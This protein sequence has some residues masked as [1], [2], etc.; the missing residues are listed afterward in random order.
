MTSKKSSTNKKSSSRSKNSSQNQTKRRSLSEQSAKSAHSAQSRSKESGRAKNEQQ[1]ASQKLGMLTPRL[2]NDII[3]VIVIAIS[4]IL[5]IAVCMNS[6]ALITASVSN[7]MHYGFGLGAYILPVMLFLFGICFFLLGRYELV[8]PRIATGMILIFLSIITLYGVNA[9]GAANRLQSLFAQDYLLNCGGYVGNGIAYVLLSLVG[10]AIS[11]VI[12]AA[13]IVGSLVLIGFSIS[14]FFDWLFAR[15]RQRKEVLE[16]NSYEAPYSRARGLDINCDQTAVAND[17]RAGGYNNGYENVGG[18][19][20]ASSTIELASAGGKSG[21]AAKT[22]M[23]WGASK[24]RDL[25][26][27][28]AGDGSG[29]GAAYDGGTAGAG[30]GAGATRM[31]DGSD[32]GAWDPDGADNPIFNTLD[33]EAGTNILSPEDIEYLDSMD[34]DQ[35]KAAMAAASAGVAGAATVASAANSAAQTGDDAAAANGYA[36][37]V[38][39]G[40]DSDLGSSA[41]ADA[42]ADTATA[43][44]QASPEVASKHSSTKQKRRNKKDTVKQSKADNNADL[45]ADGNKQENQ[46]GEFVL[47]DLKFLKKSTLKPRSAA[48]NADLAEL[49]VRLQETLHEF[50]VDADVVGWVHGP[51]VTLFKVSLASGVRV[52]KITALSDDIALA[53]ASQSVRIFSPIAGTSLVGIEIP[54]DARENVLLGDVLPPAGT[55]PMLMGIGK[56]VEGNAITADL[57][58]MPHLLIGGTTGSGKSVAINSMIMS[59]L[60]RAKPEEVRMILIDPK[61]VE[62][63][64]YNDIPHLFVP[65]V[66][67]PHKA[68]STLAWAVQEMERRLKLF[69]E[70][71]AR[72]ITQYSKLRA[73]ALEEQ[74]KRREEI[75]KRCKEIEEQRNDEGELSEELSAELTELQEEEF[76]EWEQMPSMMIVIDELADLMMV[77]GKEVETSISRIAQLARAAGI[78]MIVATQRP[79]TN[80]ITGLIKANITNRIAFNVASGIDSRV[81]LDTTGAEHLIG[82]GD[83][84]FSKPEF[85]KPLRIQGCF[86]GEDEINKVCKFLREQA[87]PDYH[88]DIFT[89]SVPILEDGGSSGGAG[90]G[91]SD[92]DLLW[93]AADIVVSSHMGSTSAIQRRL[94]VGYA[95]AGRIMDML[96][97]KGIVGPANGSKPREV[98]IDQMELESLKVMEQN[99]L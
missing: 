65:V 77:A 8:L 99:G 40:P 51:T 53:F 86:V 72:N 23:L 42:D 5:M 41:G 3:G 50:N 63:S 73:D 59:V 10:Q 33:S 94:K 87:K 1:Y 28:Q 48:S 81:I 6:D 62:L 18:Y 90:G 91:T 52:N 74:E 12:L 9:P 54:N 61:R 7:G 58:K 30:V 38:D 71:G 32:G 70:V 45:L 27:N 82:L 47:P 44:A 19:V 14:G 57:A 64:L 37:D 2:K 17:P 97:D 22:R 43:D 60:M 35:A 20:P 92:E 16:N 68:A 25:N 36:E 24:T 85:G 26:A 79:S 83:L 39:L 80:V 56:D 46:E 76:D 4:I 31:L 89:T 75:E 21:R 55:K 69:E 95:R 34:G 67:D 66:T 96:E 78:H 11:W 88:E 29:F 98:Y 13:I 84:L 49:G 93:Q 15:K